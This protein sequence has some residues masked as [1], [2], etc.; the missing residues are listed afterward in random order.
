[1][2]N[3]HPDLKREIGLVGLSAN[4]V[5]TVVGAGI[6]A[7]PAIVAAHLGAASLLAY[8]FCGVLICLVM[9]CFAEVG[10]RITL[11]GGPYAY[12]EHTFGKFAGFIAVNLFVISAFTADAAVSN[13]L[14]DIIVS[15]IPSLDNTWFRIAFF[16]LLFYGLA[17]VNVF[18]VKKGANLVKYNTIAKLIPLVLLIVFGWKDA[19][20]DN[21]IW[22][23]TPSFSQ[24][25]EVS[26][27]LIFAFQGIESALAVS[28]EVKNPVKNIPRAIL[29]S[30]FGILFIYIL[31]QQVSQ[32]VLGAELP[33]FKESPLGEVGSRI[34][35]PVGY[36]II[37]VGAAISMFGNI[38]SEI[39][40]MPRALYSAANDNI[41]PPKILSKIHERFSTPYISILV[42]S[43]FGFLIATLSGFK[44]LAVI[45]GSFLL[46]LYLGVA[47]ALIKLRIREKPSKNAFHVPGGYWIATAAILVILWLLSSLSGF[48]LLMGVLFIA[49]LSVVFIIKN[50]VER[51]IK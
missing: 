25:G 36:V 14:A 21:L 45:S 46:F 49:F 41:I 6:F 23:E 10:S 17:A 1:M 39:M 18:G 22:K 12:I 38:S 5:N 7:M 13:A 33:N 35:G 9:L 30:I 40:S 8:L 19:T 16:F 11:A 48:E 2:K 29:L 31:L 15:A 28:G 20:M 3:T 37:S 50:F 24:I 42:Y 51:K 26:L 47:F 44:E 34:F 43:S 27:I 4:L 32:G